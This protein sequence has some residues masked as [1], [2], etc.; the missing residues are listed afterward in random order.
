MADR[1]TGGTSLMPNLVCDDT[2]DDTCDDT[3][4]YLLLLDGNDVTIQANTGLLAAGL[5]ALQLTKLLLL[6]V[7][8]LHLD[9]HLLQAIL[10][11]LLKLAAV[12][13]TAV[14]QRLQLLQEPSVRIEHM[15]NKSV[16]LLTLVIA[17]LLLS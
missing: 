14:P 6:A 11:A 1:H 3:T 10:E 13:H 17:K 8:V 5:K 7:Q 4:V 15:C 16:H 9:I 12:F 2:H